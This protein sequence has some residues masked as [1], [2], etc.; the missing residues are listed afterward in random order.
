MSDGK[1]ADTMTGFFND[2]NSAFLKSA[3]TVREDGGKPIEHVLC[4]R[5]VEAKNDDTRLPS[6]RKRRDLPE[7]EIECEDD[8]AL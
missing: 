2:D 5:V 4:P 1:N 3:A 7:V 6:A 8:P